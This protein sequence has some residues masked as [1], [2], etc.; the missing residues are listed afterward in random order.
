MFISIFNC[1][2]LKKDHRYDLYYYIVT[3]PE[4]LLTKIMPFF[5]QVYELYGDKFL[6][7]IDWC[8]AVKIVNSK[9]HTTGEGLDKLRLL[10]KNINSRRL[11]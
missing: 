2:R 5:F 1:G 3:N 6:D 9:L 4:E 7:F 10:I 11:I 8:E